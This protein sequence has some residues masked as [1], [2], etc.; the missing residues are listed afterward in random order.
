MPWW[1]QKVSNTEFFAV[2]KLFAFFIPIIIQ[3]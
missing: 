1:K 2:L 3:K